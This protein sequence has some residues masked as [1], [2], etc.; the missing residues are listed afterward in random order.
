VSGTLFLVLN[1]ETEA[2]GLSCLAL[3]AL[4]RIKF[5][6]A[7]MEGEDGKFELAER[8][9]VVKLMGTIIMA[10]HVLVAIVHLS[11]FNTLFK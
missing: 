4:T 11:S 7:I 8:V 2:L 10:V 1:A 9:A 6:K 5:T 3:F